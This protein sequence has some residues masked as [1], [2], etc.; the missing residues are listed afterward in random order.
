MS[1]NL[2]II[3]LLIFIVVVAILIL[4]K[5]LYTEYAGGGSKNATKNTKHVA[6]SGVTRHQHQAT[7]QI[8]DLKK[9]PRTKSERRAVE[10]L[11]DLISEFYQ[12][13]EL[14]TVY[15]TWL[16]WKGRP[17]ELDA[18]DSSAKL[19]L[20]FSGPLHTKW[21][22]EKEPYEVY[23][24]R[25]IKDIV[26]RRLCKKNG[27]TLITI[28]MSL[29]TKHWK[30]YMLSRLYDAKWLAPNGC[31]VG[32]GNPDCKY[33]SWNN[34]MPDYIAKQKPEIIRN[35]EIERKLSLDIEYDNAK[36]I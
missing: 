26:K 6:R 29:P 28:D 16:V 14:P 35:E 33:Y 15:P 10:T 17:L 2:L 32:H 23:F 30:N 21:Y 19:A 36:R 13:L 7:D 9:H 1:F 20:E 3:V 34:N 11:R 8:K 5:Q 25:H 12:P 27:V 18:Y 24:T 4:Q 22:P 31:G